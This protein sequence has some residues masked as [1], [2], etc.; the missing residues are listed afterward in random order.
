[1]HSRYKDLALV[2]QAFRTSLPGS[3]TSNMQSP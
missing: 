1:M 2:E 3:H